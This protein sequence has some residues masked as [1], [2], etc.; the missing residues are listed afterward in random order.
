MT[1]YCFGS[2]LNIVECKCNKNSAE[3]YRKIIYV[4]IYQKTIGT[5]VM[6]KS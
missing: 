4:T 1:S 3:I 5:G 6:H 2:D